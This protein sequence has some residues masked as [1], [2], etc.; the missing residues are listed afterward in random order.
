MGKGAGWPGGG[1]RQSREGGDKRAV[2]KSRLKYKF[3]RLAEK[4]R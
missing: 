4:T 3:K 2:H 1:R